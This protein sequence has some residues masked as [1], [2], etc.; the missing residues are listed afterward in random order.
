MS[1]LG[2]AFGGAASNLFDLIRRRHVVDFID[3]RWWP[4]F[5]PSDVAIIGGLVIAF[6]PHT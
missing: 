5:N 4:V 1:A 2:I 6:W 3:L